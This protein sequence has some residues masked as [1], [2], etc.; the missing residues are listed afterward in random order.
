MEVGKK[1]TVDKKLT[2]PAGVAYTQ[3]TQQISSGILIREY[4]ATIASV[5][6]IAKAN[7][8]VAFN[9][10]TNEISYHFSGNGVADVVCNYSKN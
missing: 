10:N 2:F 6:M 5:V 1:H 7:Y 8:R 4:S 3:S 9:S